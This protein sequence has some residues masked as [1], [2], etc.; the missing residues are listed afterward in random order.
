MT[1]PV[2]SEPGLGG[3]LELESG[4]VRTEEWRPGAG[5]RVLATQW[6]PWLLLFTVESQVTFWVLVMRRAV[7]DTESRI[8]CQN[9]CTVAEHSTSFYLGPLHFHE[10]SSI[11]KL[12]WYDN[13]YVVSGF[14]HFGTHFIF[15]RNKLTK[16]ACNM[17]APSCYTVWWWALVSGQYQV[18]SLGPWCRGGAQT[19]SD[20][21]NTWGASGER[22]LWCEMRVTRECHNELSVTL[23]GHQ[24]T[25]GAHY[26]IIISHFRN[27]I[28]LRPEPTSDR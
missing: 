24:S 23:P 22:G 18:W 17:R 15:C 3:L 10:I 26:V 16:S 5:S 21:T 19:C 25:P 9:L 7:S 2:A 13:W 6:L 11:N 14:W 12:P 4:K 20:P 1:K 8:N 28:T 27:K